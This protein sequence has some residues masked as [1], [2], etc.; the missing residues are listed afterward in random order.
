[1]TPK[2][3]REGS[4]DPMAMGARRKVKERKDWGY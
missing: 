1:M 3:D 2:L 4:L